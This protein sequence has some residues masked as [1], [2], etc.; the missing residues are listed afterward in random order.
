MTMHETTAVEPSTSSFADFNVRSTTLKALARDGIE[1]P[2]PIQSAALP[3][4]LAGRDVIGQARTGSGKTLAF[5]IPA[6]ELIDPAQKAV[7]VV[8]VTPTRELAMQVGGVMDQ[9]GKPVGIRSVL[10]FGGRA[11]GPQISALRR[12][13]QVLVGTPGRMLDLIRQRALSLDNVR[14]LVLDEADGLLDQGF[15]PDVERIIGF[16]P[17]SRQTALFSATIPDWV[18]GAAKNHMKSPELITLDEHPE[19]GSSVAHRAFNI[20]DGDKLA[21]LRDLLD[22]RPNGSVIVFGRTKHGVRNL[23]RKLEREGFPVMALQGNLSQA[24]RERV[25]G[26]FRSGKVQILVATNV[27]ARGLDISTVDL[28]INM[29]LPESSDLLTH[30]IG[31]TGRMGREG[32]AIT[33]LGPADHRKWRQIERDLGSRIAQARWPGAQ[34]AL[35]SDAELV[36]E[37]P[38]EMRPRRKTA[39]RGRPQESRG[40]RTRH[41]ITC[42]SCGR[43]DH[44]PFVP[45]G[46]RPV[47]CG[48]CFTPRARR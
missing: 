30:R 33:L 28:V 1:T 17:K 40:P 44:V 41:A 35:D 48:D 20:P 31:R 18:E 12:G 29:E 4:L 13:A 36:T 9:L 47:L 39:A 14:F 19:E 5:A 32:Q 2:T 22:N 24:A 46:R 16:T 42:D 37:R 27:A 15:G 26:A 3:L 23:A 45:D 43:P 25:I 8:V 10:V 38:Q 6:I 34:E 11:A 21:V 7:Q